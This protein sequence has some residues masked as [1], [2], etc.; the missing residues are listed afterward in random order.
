[1][2]SVAVHPMALLR[3]GPTGIDLWE[4]PQCGRR[5]LL[6]WEPWRRT[7]LRAGDETVAHTGTRRKARKSE[8]DAPI[9]R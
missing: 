6:T 1:M 9:N 3:T 5:L 7:V 4:C 8:S 2:V